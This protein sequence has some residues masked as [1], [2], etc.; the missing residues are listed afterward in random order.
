MTYELEVILKQC[1]RSSY[2]LRSQS[3][4]DAVGGEIPMTSWASVGG[5]GSFLGPLWPVLGLCGRS[6]PFWGPQETPKLPREVPRGAKSAPKSG[7]ERPKRGPRAAKNTPRAAKT[8]LR[9]AQAQPRAAKER[10]RVPQERL[11]RG[12]ERPK[13]RMKSFKM[14]S[15]RSKPLF[16]E[17]CVF[18]EREHDSGGLGAYVGGLGPLLGPTLAVLGRSW[19]LRWRPWGVS[20][21]KR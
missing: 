5:L 15:G 4:L 8:I 9:I 11:K 18:L 7:Q 20:G 16:S 3:H 10:P 19:G 2:D 1:G 6:W 14:R 13:Q 12:Q 17:Q 21:P